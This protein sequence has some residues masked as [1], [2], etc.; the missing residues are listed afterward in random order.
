MENV[1]ILTRETRGLQTV[2]SKPSLRGNPPSKRRSQ[3]WEDKDRGLWPEGQGELNKKLCGWGPG[4]LCTQHRERK[5][6][7]RGL[8]LACRQPVFVPLHLQKCTVKN[9]LEPKDFTWVKISGSWK[10]GKTW[11]ICSNPGRAPIM[12]SWAAVS[13]YVLCLEW[14]VCM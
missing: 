8:Y 6:A 9:T 5:L 2:G 12:Q 3:K 13:L 1:F 14:F 11:Q 10:M 7:A 4:D